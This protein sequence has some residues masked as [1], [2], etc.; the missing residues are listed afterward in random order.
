MS[1]VRQG[2]FNCFIRWAE[3]AAWHFHD[4]YLRDPSSPTHVTNPKV[5]FE[6][7]SPST[8]FYD[9]GEKREHY[10]QIDTLREYVLLSQTAPKIELWSRASASEAWSFAVYGPGDV[11]D[12]RSVGCR[13]DVAELYE[14]GGIAR[15]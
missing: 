6:V 14:V 13:F 1:S 4:R 15:S 5:I 10:Q 7:L 9:R 8:E 2:P 3:T 11:V 12:L